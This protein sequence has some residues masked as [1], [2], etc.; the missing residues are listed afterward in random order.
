MSDW[1]GPAWASVYDS[2][3]PALRPDDPCVTMLSS[4][5]PEGSTL[6]EFGVGTGRVALALAE[7]ARHVVGVDVSGDMLAVLKQK[8]N[9][10]LREVVHASI[11]D[12]DLGRE[13]DGVYMVFNTLGAVLSAPDQV[14]TIERA[15]AHTRPG[16]AVVVETSNPV[17]TTR[18]YEY[19]QLWAVKEITDE[20]VHVMAGRHDPGRQLIRLRHIFIT[21]SGAASLPADVRYVWPAELEL[22]GRLAGLNLEATYGDWNGADYESESPLHIAVFRRPFEGA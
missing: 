22:M 2:H 12:L 15:A 6:L 8:D 14:R 5:Y 18:G 13:F 20:H 7:D 17:W 21:E 10:R 1:Q 3:F 19:N 9:G 11:V 16:G 4:V